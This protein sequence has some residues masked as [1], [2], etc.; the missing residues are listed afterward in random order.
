M[1]PRLSPNA[2]VSV[3]VP[4]RH[5]CADAPFHRLAAKPQGQATHPQY[6]LAQGDTERTGGEQIVAARRANVAV[7]ERFVFMFNRYRDLV[8]RHKA[9]NLSDNR[10]TKDNVA[11][12]R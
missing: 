10:P 6:R 7:R 9:S 12:G 1:W 3:V 11:G 5:R 8:N 4:G 2:S